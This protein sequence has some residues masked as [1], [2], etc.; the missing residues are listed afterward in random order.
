[1]A[2]TTIVEG[3]RRMVVAAIDESEE[4]IYALKWCLDN[5][6]P[7]RDAN[8]VVLLYAR[9]VTPTYSMLN[10]AGYLF[11]EEVL[12]SMDRYSRDLANS[13]LERAENICRNY[14]NIKVEKKARSGDARDVICDTVDKVGADVLVM[15]SHGYGF[16]KRAFI[17]SVSD[18]CARNAKCPVLIVKRRA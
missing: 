18:Y 8:T 17:G 2:E 6:I 10:G 4:S 9:P 13:V 7:A 12:A 15:G 16:I 1:M 11:S 3:E 5:L 14:D